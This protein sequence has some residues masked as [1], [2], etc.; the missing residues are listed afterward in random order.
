[1]KKNEVKRLKHI[2]CYE[3]YISELGEGEVFVFGSNLDGFH[4]AGSAG[5]ASFGVAGNQWRNFD[6]S[7]KPRGWQG[8]WNVKG[9]GEGPQ[10][11]T[12]GKSYALPTVNK[13]T[14]PRMRSFEEIS[15]SIQQMY[16]F[17][18]SLPDI[19]FL[20]AQDAKDGLCGHAWRDVAAMFASHEIPENV[21]FYE[22]FAEYLDT[23][24]DDESK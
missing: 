8:F 23:L 20:V 3:E 21:Y 13:I 4:G 10:R 12:H 15:K 18:R 17:A 5:F 6:Y 2:G 7:N 11:G 1:M 22:P 24:L 14:G 19:N 9:K 16:D